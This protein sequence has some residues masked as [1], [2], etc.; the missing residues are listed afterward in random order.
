M[1]NLDKFVETA[2]VLKENL[3]ENASLYPHRRYVHAFQGRPQRPWVVTTIDLHDLYMDMAKT[4]KQK[5]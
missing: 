4:L 2:A 1:A 3:V 5:G